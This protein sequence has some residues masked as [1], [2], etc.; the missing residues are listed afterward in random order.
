MNKLLTICEHKV[1][2]RRLNLSVSIAP[3]VPMQM[4]GDPAPSQPDLINY[5]NNAI[6]VPGRVEIRIRAR[7]VQDTPSRMVWCDLS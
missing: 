6:Q 3:D 7:K 2:G 1:A 5:T 4:H